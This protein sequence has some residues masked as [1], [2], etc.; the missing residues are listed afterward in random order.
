MQIC[1]PKICTWMFIAAS[2]IIASNGNDLNIHYL[3]KGKQIVVYA[4]NGTLFCN[5]NEYTTDMICIMQCILKTL[6]IA[7]ENRLRRLYS[8]LFKF[9]EILDKAKLYW[10]KHR[11][12]CQEFW[13]R[14]SDWLQRGIEVFFEAIEISYIT[15]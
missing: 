6:C 9:Y 8:I 2:F 10:W 11:S 14:G 1:L 15:L 3:V 4:H 7:K 5:K 13:G 12:H